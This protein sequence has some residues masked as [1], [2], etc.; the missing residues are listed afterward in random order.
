MVFNSVL[1]CATGVSPDDCV[2][3]GVSATEPDASDASAAIAMPRIAR[4]LI[5][6]R[7]NTGLYPQKV[8]FSSSWSHCND[9]AVSNLTRQ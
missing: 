5:R 9:P 8:A 7:R 2:I 4:F 6:K 3:G 1:D